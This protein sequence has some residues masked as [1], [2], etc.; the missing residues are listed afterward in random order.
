MDERSLVE[1]LDG[2][3]G[4]QDELADPVDEPGVD[5]FESGRLVERV[6]QGVDGAEGVRPQQ[7]R[8]LHV[9]HVVGAVELVEL[10]QHGRHLAHGSASLVAGHG[11][12]A[13]AQRPPGHPVHDEPVG[14]EL[15]SVGLDGRIADLGRKQRADRRLAPQPLVG[16]PVDPNH[17]AIGQPDLVRHARGPLQRQVQRQTGLGQG[18]TGA[19]E[20]ERVA[21]RPSSRDR[22][23][24]LTTALR[25]RCLT[26]MSRTAHARRC[27]GRRRPR[28][29]V[30]T[31]RPTPSCWGPPRRADRPGSACRC[32]R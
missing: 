9:D 6:E 17:V 16:L 7:L 31:S 30:V 21:H 27:T 25:D 2:R 13:P 18:P 12:P 24:S 10:A 4:G 3:A 5:V 19:R 32:G 20:R 29:G 26:A 15:A 23:T 11:R 28:N 8:G 22:I 1:R 14:A